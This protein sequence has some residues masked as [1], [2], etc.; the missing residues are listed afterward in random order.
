MYHF[1][2]HLSLITIVFFFYITNIQFNLL[3]AEEQKLNTF[4]NTYC[5]DCHNNKKTKGKINLEGLSLK[6]HYKTWGKV[7]SAIENYDMPPEDEKQP[8]DKER[9]GISKYIKDMASLKK[10][11]GY[12]S[13]RRL[14]RLEYDNSVKDLLNLNTNIFVLTDRVIRESQHYFNPSSGKMPS[15]INLTSRTTQRGFEAPPFA[16][17]SSLPIDSKAEHGFENNSKTT[18]LTPLLMRKYLSVSQSLLNSPSF[19]KRSKDWE[20]IFI[21]PQANIQ[22]EAKKRISA[23]I[24]KAFRKKLNPQQVEKYAQFFTTQFQAKQSF[25]DAMKETVSAI[26][27]SPD[28]LFV[29]KHQ[30]KSTEPELLD[31]YELASRL[32][33]FLWGSLPDDELL[34]LADSGKILK[35]HILEEQTIRMLKDKKVRYLSYSFFMQ[36]MHLKQLMSVSPD[37]VKFK[38][39]YLERRYYQQHVGQYAIV[40]PLLLFETILVENRSILEFLDSKFVY[41][42][43]LMANWYGIKPI[44]TDKKNARNLWHKYELSDRK[45]G[46]LVTTSAFLSMTSTPTRSSAINRGAWITSVLF[47]SPPPPP[48]ADVPPLD[49]DDIN[50]NF[51]T[52]RERFEDHRKDP[53]C[54]SCHNKIDPLGFSLENYNAVGQWRDHYANNIPIDSS[55]VYNKNKF[56]GVVTFKDTLLKNKTRFTK[57]F[58]KHMMSFALNREVE[59]YDSESIDEIS[60]KVSQNNFKFSEVV[61]GIIKSYPFRHKIEGEK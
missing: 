24:R 57:A 29:N 61:T 13:M 49:E 3:Q 45:R 21:E 4:I 56:D 37:R 30:Y 14:T 15:E 11:P 20:K 41:L 35:E 17:V 44:E 43:N 2:H 33:L 7:F 10:N 31:S 55:G 18:T 23:L 47:H 12:V 19:P 38:N 46:G 39:F 9:L 52:I 25:T 40:E 8:T 36:W 16:G 53:N 5:I 34:S 6:G 48:P 51:K 60:K 59:L 22:Q 1:K 50:K 26:L 27:S 42:N 32:A 58:I 54:A 28:F